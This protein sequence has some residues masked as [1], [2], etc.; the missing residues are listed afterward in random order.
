MYKHIHRP[1][2]RGRSEMNFYVSTRAVR[3][4][5]IV[6]VR[7]FGASLGHLWALSLI[8]TGQWAAVPLE[9]SNGAGG[10]LR[11]KTVDRPGWK[12]QELWG[13]PGFLTTP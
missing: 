1:F 10:A 8:C 2:G 13:L 12:T 4:M 6:Q 9:P 11:E 5:E 3:E 7:I